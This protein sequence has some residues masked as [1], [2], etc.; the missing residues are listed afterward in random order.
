M[1]CGW[2]VITCKFSVVFFSAGHFSVV[3]VLNG[4]FDEFK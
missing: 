2:P 3:S 4:K 1:F